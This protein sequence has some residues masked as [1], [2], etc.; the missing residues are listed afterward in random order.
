MDITMR[1][2]RTVIF[3]N[4]EYYHI[5]NRSIA[6]TQIFQTL[7]QL[8]KAKEVINYYRYPQL[9]SLSHYNALSI[10]A[11]NSYISLM[12][13]KQPLVEIYVF[14]FMPNHYHLLLKQIQDNGIIKF[15]S[16]F[17]NS[18]AK[19][20]NTRFDR[21][22]S[23]FQN[24]FKGKWIEDDEQFIHTSRYIHLNHVTSYLVTFDQLIN[25]PWTSFSDYIDKSTTPWINTQ[26]LLS[27]FSSR[28]EYK[29][30]VADQEDYQ[31]TL[32]ELNDLIL[33]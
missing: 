5:F 12:K 14:S 17:Q 24:S 19:Y 25:Y 33:E 26:F 32:N 4:N 15:V 2:K 13:K 9:Y 11:K 18:F 28:I 23:L 8:K 27:L 10:E 21:N 30:F 1:N 29:K 7:P 20:L 31:K 6:K 22:G 3:A 16:N